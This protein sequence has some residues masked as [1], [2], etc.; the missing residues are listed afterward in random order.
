MT[1][2]QNLLSSVAEKLIEDSERPGFMSH[3]LWAPGMHVPKQLKIK[4]IPG[5]NQL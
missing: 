3:L 4:V 2:V 1:L 5:A